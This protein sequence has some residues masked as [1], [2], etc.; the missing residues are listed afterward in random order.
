MWAAMVLPSSPGHVRRRSGG[1]VLRPPVPA[2]TTVGDP[3]VPPYPP[4]SSVADPV[5]QPNPSFPCARPPPAH[6]SA[7]ELLRM[8][9]WALWAQAP[10][11]QPCSHA[12]TPS[13]PALLLTGGPPPPLPSP[14][15]PDVRGPATCRCPCMPAPLRLASPPGIPPHPVVPP[16]VVHTPVA[17]GS[18][19]DFAALPLP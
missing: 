14:P 6:S 15:A 16:C 12:V 17:V 7:T 2:G 1:T 3:T 9:C 4:C 19:R 10:H 13:L 5:K 11:P 18:V 8:L